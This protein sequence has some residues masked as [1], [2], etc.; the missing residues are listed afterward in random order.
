M[1]AEHHVLYQYNL[2]DARNHYMGLIQTE[3]VSSQYEDPKYANTLE[4]QPYYQ[5]L[6]TAPIPFA[7][8]KRYKDPKF[9]IAH[10][11]AWA[12]NIVSSRDIIIFG[13][14]SLDIACSA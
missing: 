11:S 1:T 12:V 3:T 5:P 14:W 8:D 4:S 7:I 2:V 13:V 10:I 6:P 9:S